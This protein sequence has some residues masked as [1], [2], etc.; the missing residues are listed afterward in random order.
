MRFCSNQIWVRSESSCQPYVYKHVCIDIICVNPS[1]CCHRLLTDQYVHSS[2]ICND[3]SILRPDL[4]FN[5]YNTE[6]PGH[7]TNCVSEDIYRSY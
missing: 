7:A 3:D 4:A 5:S 6:A 1:I 2:V